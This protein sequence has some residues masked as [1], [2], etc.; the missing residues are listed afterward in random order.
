MEE[1][2]ETHSSILTWRI[3]VD[4]GAWQAT[5][6]GVVCLCGWWTDQRLETILQYYPQVKAES[7]EFFLSANEVI[8]LTL[9]LWDI[10]GDNFPF[11]SCYVLIQQPEPF[12]YV[13]SNLS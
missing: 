1:G 7:I 3:A 6:H 10:W 12:Q 11:G 13:I 4:R 2:K 8:V 9:Q 5:V